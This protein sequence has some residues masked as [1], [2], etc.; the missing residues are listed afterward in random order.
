MDL[1]TIKRKLDTGQYQDPWEY[2]DDI[3]LM[4]DNARTYNKRNS[5]VYKAAQKV[6]VQQDY[7]L[8]E[9]AEL[10]IVA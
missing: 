6:L 1:Q 3:W 8:L 2:T 7:I 5:R 10:V 9:A 4:I